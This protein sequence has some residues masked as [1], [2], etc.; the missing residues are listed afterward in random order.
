MVERSVTEETEKPK[1]FVVAP[2][3]TSN[4]AF[5]NGAGLVGIYFFRPDPEDT[6]SPASTV[7][8]I[9]MYS[10]TESYLAGV[11]AQ[12]F[13][14]HD[15]L[16]A[17]GG[18]VTGRI[19]NE[20][21]VTGFPEEIDFSNQLIGFLG[22][23]D[24]RIKGDFFLGVRSSYM[25]NQYNA[26]N[27]A[28]HDYFEAY[29]V[30]DGHYAKVGLIASHDTRDNVRYPT[31]GH[32]A[33]LSF[34]IAP[35]WLGAKESYHVTEAYWNQYQSITSDQVLA[36]RI[37]GR[38]TPADTPYSGLSTIGQLS[39]LRGFT[40]GEVLAENLIAAQAEYRY[41]FTERFGAVVF[42]GVS[43]LYDGGISNFNSD[44]FYASGGVGARIVLSQ[45]NKMNFR[46]DIAWGSREQRGF[47]VSVGEAF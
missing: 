17:T 45:E 43:E 46:V 44:T 12:A 5:G 20:Y 25:I 1:Q 21:N 4:P 18:V 28:S 26:G 40:S 36:L 19:N 8:V 2:M 22:R 39:D 7:S 35:D 11:F 32:E 6:V 38:F 34:T 42:A 9:G 31:E 29:N 15:Q 3:V 47:Y 33:Q 10:D 37:Y 41:F 14:D 30:E 16:R 27:A 24:K 13:L 23:V